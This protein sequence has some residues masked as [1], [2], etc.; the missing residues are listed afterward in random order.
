[1]LVDCVV[2]AQPV[3][4]HQTWKTQYNPAF[5]GE[6]R[7]ALESTAPMAL[8]ARKIIARRCAF[9][10]P[11]GGVVNLGIGVPEG[12]ARVAA[13]E[14]ILG[15]LSLTVEAG[16]IGG[17]PQGG[18]DFGAAV[19]ADAVI[20]QNQQFDFYD[21]GGLDMACLGMAQVDAHGNVNV[22]RFGKR[23]AG[24]GGFIN[25]S[26][27]ARKVA[28]AGTFTTGGLE[29]AVRDGKV[30][31]ER[32]GRERKFMERVQQITFN[33]DYAAK[34]GQP[35]YYVTERC[36]FLRTTAG[37]ELIEVA[38]GVDIER[39]ILAHMDFRPIVNNPRLMDARIF[40]DEPMGLDDMLLGLRLEDRI[41]YDA[42]RNL[43]F[44]NLE[45]MTFRTRDEVDRWRRVLD[46]RLSKVGKR[47]V[48]I[49]NY[50]DFTVDPTVSDT[51]AA[52]VRYIE[53]NYYAAV[54]RYSTSAFMR[55]KLGEALARRSVA[56][57]IFESA[58]EAHASVNLS[59]AAPGKP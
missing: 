51:Y 13:E 31:I 9:E 57:H 16:A 46:E 48:A 38:P 21:G 18:L 55:A 26:Q 17:A 22:S 20:H 5:S 56:P 59:P 49:V 4:H 35:A 15:Y 6:F 52:L 11:M 44:L 33:G 12:V 43:L 50:D 32:E 36:V 39:D 19:N 53:T 42:E 8:D 24:A 34:R 7:V 45:G 28:F 41:S 25:I 58:D 27:N 40:R 54:S 3:N 14:R 47:M 30:V 23:L 2:L 1:V 29:V 10:L 37:M